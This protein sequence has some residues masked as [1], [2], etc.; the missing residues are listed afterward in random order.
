[1]SRSPSVVA[2]FK[3]NEWNW[4]NHQHLD[5]GHFQ[6]FYRGYLAIDSGYYQAEVQNGEN[7][8]NDGNTAYGSLY[9]VNWNKRSIAT[10]Y[11]MLV[12]DPRDQFYIHTLELHRQRRR[13]APPQQVEGASEAQPP[14]SIPPMAT[15]Q[16]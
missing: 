16:A 2:E 13:A 14:S 12:I 9:D 15:R 3:I 5:A 10:Q 7:S 6:I 1:M 4:N 8:T 11:V